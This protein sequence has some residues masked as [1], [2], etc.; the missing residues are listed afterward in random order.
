M[1][2]TQGAV[3]YRREYNLDDP[4][5]RE[6]VRI[7][8]REM[9]DYE[10]REPFV[11]MQGT[12]FEKK[13]R[14]FEILLHEKDLYRYSREYP[15]GAVVRQNLGIFQDLQMKKRALDNLRFRRKKAEEE[16]N[17]QFAGTPVGT[18][19]EMLGGKVVEVDPL[20]EELEAKKKKLTKK[21][22][23]KS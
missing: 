15:S 10:S 8:E 23:N 1:A 16:R 22:H 13:L 6:L 2:F 18:A 11:V 14:G 3:D 17:A 4:A 12:I 5:D 20:P 21:I 9:E 7:F 19:L